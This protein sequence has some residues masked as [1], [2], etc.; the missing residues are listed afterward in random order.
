[1][2]VTLQVWSSTNH[3]EVIPVLKNI[4]INAMINKGKQY[5]GVKYLFGTG[6]YPQTGKFD[7]STFTQYVFGKYG[8]K[9]PRLARQQAA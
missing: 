4:D 6:P 7:C 2:R 5:L 3:E 1:M 8:V 9:L